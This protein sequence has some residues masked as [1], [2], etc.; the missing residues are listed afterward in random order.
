MDF[1]LTITQP[2]ADHD[3]LD[4]LAQ[5]IYND[6]GDD[7][8]AALGNFTTEVADQSVLV[9]VK[10]VAKGDIRDLMAR[11]YDGNEF[12]YIRVSEFVRDAGG[13]FPIDM[14]EED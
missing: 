3:E 13:W 4:A 1:K 9:I 8:D 14:D 6:Y 10:E 5:D 2:G 11:I 7:W 12:C